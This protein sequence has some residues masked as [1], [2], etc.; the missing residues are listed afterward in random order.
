MGGTVLQSN[1]TPA[2]PASA[3]NSG[4]KLGGANPYRPPEP[5]HPPVRVET[6]LFSVVEPSPGYAVEYNDWYERDHQFDGG[7]SG[8]GWFSNRRWVATKRLKDLR[9]PAN[10]A[11]DTN[12]I[13]S[14]CQIYW[15]QQGFAETSEQWALDQWVKLNEQHR[16]FSERR[17]FHSAS[18]RHLST[19][20]NPGE[21]VPL[22]LAL[23]HPFAGLAMIIVDDGGAKGRD[24]AVAELEQVAAQALLGDDI[25]ILAS[26]ELLRRPAES[27]A[28]PP[29]TLMKG[30]VDKLLQ[31]AFL[32][33]D[34]EELWS[35][36][37]TYAEA[38]SANTSSRVTFAG[39]FIP[40]IPGTTT[41]LDQL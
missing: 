1:D 30:D 6:M 4:V 15:R 36:L 5:G 23:Q 31:L 41:Y 35:R 11:F 7:M 9:F 37:Q 24:A 39:G 19:A 33:G 21:R 38:V 17:H 3:G 26:W 32:R 29:G 14:L 13:G 22:E 34:P 27:A 28:R 8:A 25:P 2:A 12:A 10:S 18:Y 20:T 16:I 40:T